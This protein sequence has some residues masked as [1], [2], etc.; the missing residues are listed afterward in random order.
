MRNIARP[1]FPLPAKKEKKAAIP[2]VATPQARQAQKKL[3]NAT[4]PAS[5]YAIL[6]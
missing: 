6:L 2:N 5:P 4:I 1:K 3:I